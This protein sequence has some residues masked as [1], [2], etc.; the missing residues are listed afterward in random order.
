MS[1]STFTLKII[2]IKGKNYSNK[3]HI[4]VDMVNMI[5]FHKFIWANIHA[6]IIK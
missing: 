5:K 2:S 3:K 1:Q 6:K 4:D